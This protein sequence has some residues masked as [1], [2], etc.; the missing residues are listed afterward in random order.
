[1]KIAISGT[2][3]VGKSTY[4]KDFI[5]HWSCYETPE[6][7]YRELIKEKNLPHSKEGTEESQRIVLDAL[8]DQ[9]QQNS[10]SEFMIFDRCVLDNLAYSSWLNL[11]GKV[12]DKFLD[13]SRIIVREALKMLDIVFF[14]PL[15]K[16]APVEFK[17]D[18]LRDNDLV[19]REEIDNIFKIFVHSYRQGDGRVFA[20]DDAPP[21][22]EI[23]GN[24]EQR[25]KLTELYIDTNGKPHGEDKSLISD[26]YTGYED[27][28]I[29]SDIY[30]GK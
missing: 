28:N 8:C 1:M 9:L 3:C 15:T 6:K 14:L 16:V 7:S 5:K 26:I 24:P 23:F 21:I 27:K 20:A 11:N 2:H 29:I 10:K 18:E 13:Q 12:S 17:E 25:I 19:Y 22:I 4:I 30:T